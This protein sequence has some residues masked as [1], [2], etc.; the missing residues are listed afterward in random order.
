MATFASTANKAV[1]EAVSVAT[2]ASTAD[3]A[4]AKAASTADEDVAMIASRADKAVAEAASTQVDAHMTGG[5]SAS[6]RTCVSFS[7]SLFLF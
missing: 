5:G 7:F 6:T 4:V 2:L 1:A 3:K